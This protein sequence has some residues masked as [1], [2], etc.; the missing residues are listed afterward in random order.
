LKAVNRIQAIRVFAVCA[1][2]FF[3]SKIHALN[4]LKM[5]PLLRSDVMQSQGNS[6]YFESVRLVER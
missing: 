1:T 3:T 6:G 5:G 4:S 2:G